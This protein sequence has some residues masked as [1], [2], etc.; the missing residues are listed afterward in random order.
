MSY[1]RARMVQIPA[2]KHFILSMQRFERPA[3]SAWVRYSSD[4][5]IIRGAE[6]LS[7]TQMAF[8]V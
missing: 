4:W 8:P 1:H 6:R 7:L 3:A 5:T 2:C